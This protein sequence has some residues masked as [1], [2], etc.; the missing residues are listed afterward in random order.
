M[1]AHLH[2]T[3][4][5]L[6][7]HTEDWAYHYPVNSLPQLSSLIYQKT[8][9]TKVL[10]PYSVTTFLMR[11]ILIINLIN[12]SSYFHQFVWWSLSFMLSLLYLTVSCGDWAYLPSDAEDSLDIVRLNDL[13]TIARCSSGKFLVVGQYLTWLIS[14]HY[15]RCQS[16]NFVR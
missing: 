1:D 13:T 11:L 6:V 12:F 14:Q 10:R 5:V 3:T 9:L 7:V 2:W 15:L 16:I 4:E 8:A